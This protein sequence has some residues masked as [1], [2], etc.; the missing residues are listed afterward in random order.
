MRPNLENLFL[1]LSKRSVGK[2]VQIPDKEQTGT[3]F[4]D[5]QRRIG[6]YLRALWGNDF[7]MTQTGRNFGN[8]PGYKPF[9]QHQAIYLPDAYEDHCGVSGAEIYRAASAHAA[10]HAVYSKEPFPVRSLDN[11]QIAVISVVEDARIEKLAMREFPGL[12]QL[13]SRLHVITSDRKET[14]GAYLDRLA[15]A[16][17]DE[18][19]A[20][21]DPW[22]EQGR[23]LFARTDPADSRVSMEI[24]IELARAFDARGI[25]FRLNTD[26]QTAPYRDD[27]RCLWEEKKTPFSKLSKRKSKKRVHKFA[28]LFGM[29]DEVASESDGENTKKVSVLSA[30]FNFKLD[31]GNINEREERRS[32]SAPFHYPE[33]D[34]QAQIER[35]SW[36]LL[37]E[38]KARLGEL[39]IIDDI[40]AQHRH[41]ISRMKVLLDAI[42]P[43]GVQR[44]RKLEEGDEIDINAAI[45]AQVDLRMGIQ[46]DTRIM[47][48]S[49]RKTRDISVLV[50]LDLS[51]STNQ[52]VQGQ[53][54]TVLELTRQ[55][56]VLLA[57]AIEKVGD[58]FAIHGFCSDSRHHVEYYRFKDFGHPHD[59]AS[60]ARLAGMTAQLSTRMG[61]AI[62]HATHYLGKQKSSKK[63]LM[64]IT[65]G[66][67]ADVD[68]RDHKYLQ[69]DAKKAVEAAGRSGI[70]TYCMSLD[71]K[72]D[73]YVSRIFGQRNYM[74]VDHVKRLPE[75]LPILY[76]GLTR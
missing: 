66:E 36:V 63:L 20:D 35:P 34:Y 71:P 75:K 28:S 9:L 52:K 49:V 15:R 4:T 33:W 32:V 25:P 2:I 69:Y 58:P 61:A 73:Q 74:V 50:L 14:A 18:T 60:K 29:T 27:N 31:F 39:K 12:K 5:V 30:I 59:D 16:L 72:A 21:D 23:L 65:D 55:A 1:K 19:Y 48:S 26:L 17:L 6:M 24:G 13:W 68:V 56:C 57:D 40:I 7:I 8:H 62:R 42:Q 38:K 51:K 46:P 45:R 76:A 11:W 41:L 37:L 67:P 22:I 43:E 70:V 64:V 47:M 44:I 53:D 10:A 3:L 54:H